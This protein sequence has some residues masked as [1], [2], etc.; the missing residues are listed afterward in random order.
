MTA[1]EAGDD[2]RATG[3]PIDDFTLTFITPLRPDDDDISHDT[4]AK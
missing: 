3:Q 2:I 1:L 4:L